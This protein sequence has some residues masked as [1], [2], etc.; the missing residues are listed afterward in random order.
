MKLEM[1]SLGN[2]RIKFS[3]QKDNEDYFFILEGLLTGKEQ[4][5]PRS[6]S[7]KREISNLQRVRTHFAKNFL[8]FLE[9]EKRI[10]FLAAI[11]DKLSFI[12]INLIKEED[13]V[14]L[15]VA[16]NETGLNLSQPDLIRVLFIKLIGGEN[17]LKVQELAEEWDE[18]V[19]NTVSEAKNRGDVNDEVNDFLYIF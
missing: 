9:E 15:F 2:S 19:V 14:D 11:L 8:P 7:I 3:D 6:K 4:N 10:E 1:V 17:K 16:L 12:E 13:I 18:K 5:K